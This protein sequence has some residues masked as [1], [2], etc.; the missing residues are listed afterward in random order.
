MVQVKDKI[1][2]KVFKACMVW[3]DHPSPHDLISYYSFLHP[4]SGLARGAVMLLSQGI[5]IQCSLG[6]SLHWPVNPMPLSSFPFRS[7]LLSR[8]LS[9]VF[10]EHPIYKSINLSPTLI[11]SP[12]LHLIFSRPY[13][14]PTYRV[15]YFLILLSVYLSLVG[16]KL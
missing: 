8:L 1:L 5:H 15:F 13:H 7:L 9:E 6:L 16:H 12:L 4:C 10:P 14:H 11:P 3:L 2:T